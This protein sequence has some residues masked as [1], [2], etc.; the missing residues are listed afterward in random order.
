MHH[1][2]TKGTAS[3]VAIVRDGYTPA[4]PT[5]RRLITKDDWVHMVGWDRT[6]HAGGG[7]PGSWTK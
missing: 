5:L 4:L 3:T 1:T 7:D 2:G 6:N